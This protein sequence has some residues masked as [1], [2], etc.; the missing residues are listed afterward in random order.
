MG[1]NSS[2]RT[3]QN[4]EGPPYKAPLSS[5]P[6]GGIRSLMRK[7]L[8]EFSVFCKVRSELLRP[9]FGLLD[10]VKHLRM[11]LRLVEPQ[12]FLS[13]SSETLSFLS[14]KSQNY[15]A[16]VRAAEGAGGITSITPRIVHHKTPE[17]PEGLP[18]KGPLSTRPPREAMGKNQKYVPDEL[19]S[20]R[21]SPQSLE[22][23]SKMFDGV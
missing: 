19:Q 20:S 12:E 17:S 9:I 14:P 11:C 22:T 1:R 6:V 4:P 7:N 2:K 10:P 5:G 23:H 15:P 21:D 18:S 3:S 8:G 13:I 16:R